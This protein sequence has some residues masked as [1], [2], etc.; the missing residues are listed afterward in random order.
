LLRIL[1]ES[2]QVEKKE[3]RLRQNKE[4]GAAAVRVGYFFIL[5]GLCTTSEKIYQ[6][7]FLCLMKVP[8]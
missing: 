5:V 8:S 2:V 1:L 6:D 4:S 3:V 7:F